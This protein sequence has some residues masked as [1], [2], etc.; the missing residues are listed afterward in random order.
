M[1]KNTAIILAM[2]FLFTACDSGSVESAT[3][4][5]EPTNSTSTVNSDVTEQEPPA[6]SSET[7]KSEVTTTPQTTEQT[8]A[9]EPPE[10]PETSS[11]G[12]SDAFFKPGIWQCSEYYFY[13]FGE[14][15]GSMMDFDS[16]LGQPFEYEVIDPDSGTLMFHIFSADDQSSASAQVISDSE[17]MLTWD[18]GRTDHLT[19][20]PGKTLEDIEKEIGNYFKP[21]TWN[22]DNESYYFFNE[23][24]TS[25]D[26]LSFNMGVGI[27][28][29][30]EVMSRSE[31]FVNFHQGSADNSEGVV[32]SNKTE[33]SF[34]LTWGNGR[35]QN[36]TYVSPLGY[37]EFKFYTDEQLH[38]IVLKYYQE[39][40]NYTPQYFDVQHNFDGTSTVH[41]FDLVDDRSSTAALCTLDRITLKGTDDIT[42][43]EI[44]LSDYAE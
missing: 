22:C 28:F 18:F 29:N 23:D 4:S 12:E 10:T 43:T 44:D 17:I 1:K 42:G 41:L 3:G 25:G 31:G 16:N 38:D 5:S 33:D 11:E 24:G 8:T 35:S 13:Q 20:L 15:G 30:Y 40:N 6:Q 32:I 9:S 2:V 37:D 34:T 26:T 21:G 14:H 36:F 27:G 19:Y 39:D 7:P